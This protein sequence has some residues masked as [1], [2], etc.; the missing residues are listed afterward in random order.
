[1]SSLI[2]L[3][4]VWKIYR[5]S[6]RVQVEALRGITLD[7][8]KGEMLAVMGPSGSG[9]STLMHI[10]GCLDRPTKGRVFL[11]GK[12]V[13]KLD[14]DM[15]AK[16]R[17]E[18][19]G[20]VFQAYNLIP[21]LTALENVMMPMMFAGLHREERVKRARKLLE[22]V[23]MMDRANHKPREMSGGEQQRV[24]IARALANDPEIILADEPTGNLDSKTGQQIVNLFRRL[25]EE[26]GKTVVVVTHDP[27]W[28][29]AVDRTVK[30]MDGKIVEVVV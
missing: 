22:D 27:S 18:R 12:D 8:E 2:K 19:I 6:E 11:A 16:I 24:A 13:S 1:M 25:N 9:K 28:M 21:T 10:M 30:I 29:N 17:R 7:V 26:K 14:E 3:N 20:F 5:M 23:G 4:N 15:L